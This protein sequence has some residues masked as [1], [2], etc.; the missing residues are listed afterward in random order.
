VAKETRRRIDV[1]GVADTGVFVPL[2][3]V[4]F[5]ALRGVATAVGA[6][7]IAPIEQSLDLIGAGE[8]A[9]RRSRC[10]FESSSTGRGEREERRFSPRRRVGRSVE[11]I[12][13]PTTNHVPI[14]LTGHY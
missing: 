8:E 1:I 11:M 7:G 12:D 9:G 2:L 14:Q 3:V 6:I 4:G 10:A 5:A 13:P